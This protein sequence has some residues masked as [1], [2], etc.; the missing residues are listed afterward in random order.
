[1]Q[2]PVTI[3]LDASGVYNAGVTVPDLSTVLAAGDIG[4]TA[5]THSAT[6]VL[7]VVEIP[8]LNAGVVTF[9][10]SRDGGATWVPM[11]GFIALTSAEP[12][13]TAGAT[14]ATYTGNQRLTL[15]FFLPGTKIRMVPTAAQTASAKLYIGTTGPAI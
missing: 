2:T 14:A 1:M 6:F 5:G 12:T 4:Y 15:G 13:L 9:A 8:T 11:T 10:T 3:A 7:C